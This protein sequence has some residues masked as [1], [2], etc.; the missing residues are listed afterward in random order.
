MSGG[1]ESGGGPRPP[2]CESSALELNRA[3][4]II[5]GDPCNSHIPRGR[6]TE[7]RGLGRQRVRRDSPSYQVELP[8]AAV[9]ADRT[10]SD[11]DDTDDRLALYHVEVVPS[12]VRESGRGRN[13]ADDAAIVIAAEVREDERGGLRTGGRQHS[14]HSHKCKRDEAHQFQRH[15]FLRFWNPSKGH[16]PLPE[17]GPS[18]TLVGPRGPLRTGLSCR[19]VARAAGFESMLCTFLTL[20]LPGLTGST[21]CFEIP[22]Y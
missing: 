22:T 21:D 1:T 15:A 2:P 17:S 20:E 19:L 13:R 4:E 18:Q 10:R 6:C 5:R 9:V 8:V 12:F 3:E 7:N 11:A 14:H 16:P